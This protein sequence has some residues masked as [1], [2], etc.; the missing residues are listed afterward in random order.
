MVHYGRSTE[1]HSSDPGQCEMDR[2]ACGGI[3]GRPDSRGAIVRIGPSKS[4]Q[5]R[6]IAW[7]LTSIVV[8]ASGLGTEDD[9]DLRIG[10]AAQAEEYTLLDEIA[11]EAGADYLT[12]NAIGG[13]KYSKDL[14]SAWN[15]FSG[16][17]VNDAVKAFSKIAQTRDAQESDRV[18]ALY[19][20]GV[21]NAYKRPEGDR[22]GAQRAF[23][24]VVDRYPE[25]P[26]APWALLELGILHF[27]VTYRLDYWNVDLDNRV[28][29][30][31]FQRVI[32]RYPES[33]A[34][35]EAVLRLADSYIDEVDGP[36][37]EIGVQL[38]ENHLAAYPGNPLATA[39]YRYLGR[40]FAIEKQD[41]RK[42]VYYMGRAVEIGF[43]DPFR[44]SQNNWIVAVLYERGLKQP[45]NAIQWYEKIVRET[46]Q[47]R[48]AYMA[49][50]KISS[51]KAKLAER[52]GPGGSISEPRD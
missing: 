38:L 20:L 51:L 5:L 2:E 45:E 43:A 23:Q 36:E 33:P 46:P 44:Q 3:A 39:M 7:V 41:Y 48:H 19:G 17:A 22:E 14:R 34:L 31:Y 21:S 32:D 49:K 26:V 25:S 1:Y 42:G 37:V 50:R 6:R 29:R 10:I 24:A 47:A 11:Q 4:K 9:S 16:A 27:K 13:G 15:L 30:S 18:Q 8:M 35:H 52:G 12:K 28:A 40:W